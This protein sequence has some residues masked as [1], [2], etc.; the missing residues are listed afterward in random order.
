MTSSQKIIA[1]LVFG[2]AIVLVFSLKTKKS[3][4]KN[5]S[6]NISKESIPAEPPPS[7]TQKNSSNKN[8]VSQ[9]VQNSAKSSATAT[10]SAAP[11]NAKSLTKEEI[12]SVDKLAK[13]M[14][15]A[16]QTSTTAKKISEHLKAAGLE[17][18]L[19]ENSNPSTGR[20]AI[21]RTKNTLVGT[22]YFHSQIFSADKGKDEL[23]QHVSFEIRPGA[24]SMK[25]AQQIVGQSLPKNS[26]VITDNP[27]Y[28]LWR[29]PSGY[30]TWIKTMTKE[31]L[32]DDPFNAY[33]SQ[34]VGTIRI[35]TEQ[36]IEE[37]H[38]H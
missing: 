37:N 25:R 10:P 8:Y 2:L 29:L 20:M 7:R 18:S 27:D 32:K 30:I 28:K 36:D 16:L 33:T 23:V 38:Q 13:V 12:A 35:V 11:I 17:P 4:L 21:L 31:D 5:D 24:D 19:T 6:D 34:D 3:A 14:V 26:Q 1:A 22:R 9:S 15:S